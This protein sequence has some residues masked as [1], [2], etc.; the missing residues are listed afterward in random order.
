MITRLNTFEGVPIGTDNFD[1]FLSYVRSFLGANFG[2]STNV[3]SNNG[4][5]FEDEQFVYKEKGAAPVAGVY[6]F[7]PD[8]PT[9]GVGSLFGKKDGEYYRFEVVYQK[10]RL[11]SGPEDSPQAHEWQLLATSGD[12]V[13]GTLQFNNTSPIHKPLPYNPVRETNNNYSSGY[14]EVRL[15]GIPQKDVIYSRD[16]LANTFKKQTVAF[17]KLTLGAEYPYPIHN[18]RFDPRITGTGLSPAP[19]ALTIGELESE[20]GSTL[21]FPYTNFGIDYGGHIL[22]MRDTNQG[23]RFVYVPQDMS[24]T[25]EP[26][27]GTFKVTD[28]ARGEIKL[29]ITPTQLMQLLV[30]GETDTS[31]IE[32]NIVSAEHLQESSSSGSV[33]YA[34]RY[35]ELYDGDANEVLLVSYVFDGLSHTVREIPQGEVSTDI[36]SILLTDTTGKY[37]DSV[38]LGIKYNAYIN[39]SEILKTQANRYEPDTFQLYYTSGVIR[40]TVAS[41]ADVRAIVEHNDISWYN[42]DV[43]GADYFPVSR[44]TSTWYSLIPVGEAGFFESFNPNYSFQIADTLTLAS[45]NDVDGPF[46]QNDILIYNSGTS[47]FEAIQYSLDTLVN[48]NISGAANDHVLRFSGGQWI[49]S[50]VPNVLGY[51]PVTPT[52]FNA[53]IGDHAVHGAISHGNQTA[54][55]G[56]LIIRDSQG[57]ASVTGPTANGHIA[58]KEYVDSAVGAGSG[59]L[60]VHINNTTTAHGATSSGTR[61]TII[62][63]GGTASPTTR[64]DTNLEARRPEAGT[65]GNPSTTMSNSWDVSP[66][67]TNRVVEEYIRRHN[68]TT[69]VHGATSS[70]SASR[71]I[72]RDNNGRAR[73]ASPVSGSNSTDIA[74]TSWVRTLVD[75]IAGATITGGSQ[76]VKMGDYAIAWSGLQQHNFNQIAYHTGPQL[77]LVSGK[78]PK[79]EAVWAQANFAPYHDSSGVVNVFQ[80]WSVNGSRQPTAQV[81]YKKWGGGNSNT[82][83][84]VFWIIRYT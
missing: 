19:S 21:R 78:T 7:A 23:K 68:N 53:H 80:N 3:I 61:G 43:L 44:S 6:V 2:F 57:R 29:N 52:A 76:Y 4:G 79:A 67:A 82:S 14:F 37:G 9:P 25:P 13:S 81:M 32:F 51:V 20:Y 33:T 47:S 55:G 10:D 28:L 77:P 66:I 63:R 34:S 36:G 83:S 73:V 64:G 30:S 60:T 54:I 35:G 71:L 27:G 1:D 49:N 59:S 48:V 84:R 38:I 45:L 26:E 5:F 69:S 22:L 16:T 72:I 74:T 31:I 15:N 70:A 17:S 12:V 8:S 41:S 62:L 11:D 56:R 75:S 46:T 65:M 24:P 42:R 50:T 39:Y 18:N 40:S 58:T